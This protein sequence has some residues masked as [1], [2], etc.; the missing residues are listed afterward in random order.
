MRARR[1][2]LTLTL[3]LT[4]ALNLT[5][6]L[7]IALALPPALT[8]ARTLRRQGDPLPR[9]QRGRRGDLAHISP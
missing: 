9:H 6:T 7:A 4:L 1:S 3:T 2:A 8:L 5:L